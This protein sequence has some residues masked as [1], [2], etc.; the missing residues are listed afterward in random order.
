MIIGTAGLTAG[1]SLKK[2]QDAG[3]TPDAG[4]IL[5]TGATGGVGSLAV[6]ML[7]QQEYAVVAV[8][9]KS[10][11]APFLAGLG[12]RLILSRSDLLQGCDRPLMKERFAGVLDVVGGE[13]LSAAIKSTVYG[14]VVTCCGVAG[15]FDLPLNVYPFI[16]RGVSLFGIDSALCPPSVREEVWRRLA[17]KWKPTRL[18]ES[19]IEVPL[20]GLEEKFEAMLRGELRG[21]TV[22]NLLDI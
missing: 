19:A 9:G 6:C 4:D 13:I 2:L 11:Q 20:S 22:V 14:G 21:R 16:L 8:T 1:L 18:M 17:G 15:S 5:V 10:S 12:A 3:V 7:A